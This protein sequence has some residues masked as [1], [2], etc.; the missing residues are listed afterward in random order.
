MSHKFVSQRP[1]LKAH[2]T[3]CTFDDAGREGTKKKQFA[4]E[5]ALAADGRTSGQGRAGQSRV[6]KVRKANAW[7]W[8]SFGPS[9]VCPSTRQPG[10]LLLLLLYV[11]LMWKYD[12][13]FYIYL[14]AFVA[15][16][17]QFIEAARS[18]QKKSKYIFA[19]PLIPFG[20]LADAHILNINQ[21]TYVR[22]AKT[23]TPSLTLILSLSKSANSGCVFMLCV[24]C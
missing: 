12:L 16:N 5:F 23:A 14:F 1:R 22:H 24:C 21:T 20:K 3:L 17:L 2:Y 7:S 19:C 9:N 11:F 15:R 4:V 6:T 13:I 10:I 18:A 8:H